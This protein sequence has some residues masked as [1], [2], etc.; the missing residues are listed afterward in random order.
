MNAYSGSAILAFRRHVTIR[1]FVSVKVILRNKVKVKKQNLILLKPM[2]PEGWGGGGQSGTE[3]RKLSG[4]V[5]RDSTFL[6]TKQILR[7]L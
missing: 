3:G 7:A 5:T 4:G 6:R 1:I 2:R